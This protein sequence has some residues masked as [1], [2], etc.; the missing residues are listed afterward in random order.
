M[1]ST[2]EAPAALAVELEK[3]QLAT[4]SAQALA[5]VALRDYGVPASGITILAEN[6]AAAVR[7]T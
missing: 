1:P 3:N 7:K 2:N 6:A 5:N 4:Q